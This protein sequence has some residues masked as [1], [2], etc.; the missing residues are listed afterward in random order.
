MLYGQLVA[1]Y[2]VLVTML[3]DTIEGIL[4]KFYEANVHSIPIIL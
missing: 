3:W 1:A 2:F 4:C